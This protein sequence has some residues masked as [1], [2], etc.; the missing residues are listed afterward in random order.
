VRFP[1]QFVDALRP[2]PF[3]QPDGTQGTD[4]SVDPASFRSLF[5]AGAIA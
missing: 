1:N 3:P 4:L 5:A 2:R